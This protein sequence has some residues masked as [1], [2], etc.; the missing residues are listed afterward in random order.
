MLASNKACFGFIALVGQILAGSS[1]HRITHFSLAHSLCLPVLQ[2]AEEWQGGQ[3]H[4]SQ[5]RFQHLPRIV[6]L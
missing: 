2:W 3:L 1:L 5:A 4:K 6:L